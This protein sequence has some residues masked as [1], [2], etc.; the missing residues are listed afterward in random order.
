MLEDQTSS[1]SLRLFALRQLC[2]DE[3]GRFYTLHIML[4]YPFL[5]AISISPKYREL[6]QLAVP[7]NERLVGGGSH[8]Y[9]V[10]AGEVSDFGLLKVVGAHVL[11]AIVSMKAFPA[12]R[13]CFLARI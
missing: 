4:A 2:H 6:Y 7:T 5:F 13:S 8:S 12:A 10:W 3:L 11:V 1:F 9:V